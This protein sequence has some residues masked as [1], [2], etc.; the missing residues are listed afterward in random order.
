M[1]DDELEEMRRLQ[2]ERERLRPVDR[3]H[4]GPPRRTGDGFIDQ[5]SERRSGRI[6]LM[7]FRAHPRVKAIILAIKRR[8]D[9]P[10]LPVL[11]ELMVDAYQEKYGAIPRDQ[12]PTDEELAAQ[13]E[14]ERDKRDGY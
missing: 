3:L 5:R 11:L 13:I 8:D 7:P 9:V 1:E 14:R 12:L 4:G 6:I 10:S 2:Q